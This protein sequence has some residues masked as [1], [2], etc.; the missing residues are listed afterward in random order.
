MFGL[1][2]MASEYSS[3]SSSS[4]I[5]ITISISDCENS[6]RGANRQIYNLMQNF[7]PQMGQ[8][9]KRPHC[10]KWVGLMGGCLD[11]LMGVSDCLDSDSDSGSPGQ[12]I[13]IK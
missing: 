9:T 13:K 2:E 7:A 6:T 11:G 12:T 3:N 1:L 5:S 10:Q 4:S 8:K